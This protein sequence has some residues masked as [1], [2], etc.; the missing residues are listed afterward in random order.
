MGCVRRV[1]G[2]VTWRRS[3]RGWRPVTWRCQALSLALS[4]VSLG[5][6]DVA[7][8]ASLGAGDVASLALSLASL[9]AGDV[10]LSGVVVGVVGGQ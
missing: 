3:G 1:G 5:A 4:L 10:A 9:G 6:S 8:L 7:S 2:V